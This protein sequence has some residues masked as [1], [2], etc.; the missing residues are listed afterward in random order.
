[1]TTPARLTEGG[2]EKM[3]REAME[4]KARVDV[5]WS[6]GKRDGVRLGLFAT[7]DALEKMVRAHA[8][9]DVAA[10][11]KALTELGHARMSLAAHVGVW[12]RREAQAGEREGQ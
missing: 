8:A 3:L 5:E 4:L 9:A 11:S 2:I 6:E 10:F 1:M 12:K 7:A